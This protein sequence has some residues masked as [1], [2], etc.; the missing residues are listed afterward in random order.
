MADAA[1]KV[2]CPACAHQLELSSSTDLTHLVC[3]HCEAQIP[4]DAVRGENEIAEEK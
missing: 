2:N 1:T 3:P 4:A